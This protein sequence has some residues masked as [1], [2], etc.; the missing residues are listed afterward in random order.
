MMRTAGP[1]LEDA[2][3]ISRCLAWEP[4]AWDAFVVRHTPFVQ[5]ESRRQLFRYRGRADLDDV[6]DARQE[7]FALLMRDGARTLRQFRGDSSLSTW[8]AYVVRSV[9][10]QIASHEQEASLAFREIVYLPPTEED[11]P[12]EGL[13]EAVGRLPARDQKLLRLF[14]YEGKKYR[15]IA[16]EMGISINSVGPLLSR[17]LRA[18]RSLIPR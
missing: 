12:P 18:A 13:H 16:R 11:L 5:A 7:V 3:L 14:F 6:E 9:C 4:Q 15:Q 1:E 10:R 17:A 8:L 2:R